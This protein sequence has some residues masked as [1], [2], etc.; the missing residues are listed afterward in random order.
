[1][2]CRGRHIGQILGAYKP[3]SSAFLEGAGGFVGEIRY[4]GCSNGSQRCGLKTW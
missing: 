4:P 1:M 2:L 3:H